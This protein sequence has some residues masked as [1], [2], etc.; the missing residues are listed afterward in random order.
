MSALGQVHFPITIRGA[1]DTQLRAVTLVAVVLLLQKPSTD[2]WK[3]RCRWFDSAPGH[4]AVGD[5]IAT[6]QGKGR[7][8]PPDQS[9]EDYR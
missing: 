4:H 1:H 5:A 3:S 7:T 2:D 8:V 9:F 6:Y